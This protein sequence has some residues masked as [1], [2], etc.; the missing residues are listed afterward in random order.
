MDFQA[1]TRCSRQRPVRGQSE[2]GVLLPMGVG[3]YTLLCHLAGFL[4]DH[5]EDHTNNRISELSRQKNDN[6]TWLLLGSLWWAAGQWGYGR[7][8]IFARGLLSTSASLVGLL[9]ECNGVGFSLSK[10]GWLASNEGLLSTSEARLACNM[11]GKSYSRCTTS[12]CT[13]L[14]ACVS[15]STW[16]WTR[17]IRAWNHLHWLLLSNM[18][19]CWAMELLFRWD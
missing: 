7:S 17:K 2:G 5:I 13:H 12:D 9:S 19:C 18:A 16:T 6:S 14:H 3:L 8:G 1:L 4:L 15:L 11:N 10:L